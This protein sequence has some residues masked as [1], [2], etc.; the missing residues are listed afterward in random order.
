MDKEDKRDKKQG[1]SDKK[2]KSAKKDKSDKNSDIKGLNCKWSFINQTEK[3]HV[4]I[5]WEQ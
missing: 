2:D 5:Q 4:H 3:I 1:K